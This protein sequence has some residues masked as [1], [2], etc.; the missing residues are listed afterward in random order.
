VRARPALASLALLL[1]PLAGCVTPGDSAPPGPILATLTPHL[2]WPADSRATDGYRVTIR[3]CPCPA[4]P[5]V[6][7]GAHTDIASYDVPPGRLLYGRAYSWS[8]QGCAGGSCN[9]PNAPLYFRTPADGV[10]NPP[11]GLTAKA[12][13]SGI[14]LKWTPPTDNGGS[15]LTG[16]KVLRSAT[17]GGE[18]TTVAVGTSPAYNDLPLACGMAAHYRVL[19]TNPVGDGAPT[20]EVHVAAPACKLPGAPVGLSARV[21]AAGEVALAWSPPRSGPVSGYLVYRSAGTGFKDPVDSGPCAGLL[22]RD[23][24]TDTG[25]ADGKSYAYAVAA[26]NA[27]GTGPR[28][29]KVGVKLPPA[30]VPGSSGYVV[31]LDGKAVPL[32]SG[33]GTDYKAIGTAEPDA[34]VFIDCTASTQPVPNKRG[35]T[36]TWDRLADG[37]WMYDARVHRYDDAAPAPCAPPG[38]AFAG[39][40]YPFKD[41]DPGKTK[42]DPWGFYVR[43]CTSWVAW[44]MNQVNGFFHNTMWNAGVSG[45]WGNAGTW[46]DNAKKLHYDVDHEAKAGAVAEWEPNNPVLKSSDPKAPKP[47]GHVAYVLS[48]SPDGRTIVVEDYNGFKH[49]GE[50][51]K[52]RYNQ[53]TLSLDDG[54]A[55]YWPDNFIHIAPGT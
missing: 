3:Q 51:F 33:P 17:A 41:T 39:D 30:H 4:G 32:R 55:R 54:T 23:E 26:V 20:R 16:Y 25:L 13:A 12:S 47:V 44:R 31:S 19:A 15:P 11:T 37:S 43:Q 7:A 45:R 18:T 49:D 28:G 40:D 22:A 24:C 6:I 38:P 9:D 48:V 42:T 46:D 27:A 8:V 53:S 36:T 21:E 50:S 14:Q 29:A 1:I 5:T 2:E 10:P 34:A 35:Q 52:L